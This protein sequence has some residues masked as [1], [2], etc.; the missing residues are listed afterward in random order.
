MEL[1]LKAKKRNFALALILTLGLIAGIPCIVLGAINM[2]DNKGFVALLV[3]GI[4]GT[5]LG[6]YGSPLMWTRLATVNQELT[7]VQAVTQEH[8]YTV[9]DLAQRLSVNGKTASATLNNCIRKGY[10]VGYIREGDRLV[11][12]EP[13]P[14]PHAV[15][16]RLLPLRRNGGTHQRRHRPL[17]LLRQRPLRPEQTLTRPPRTLHGRHP[18]SVFS[19]PAP[20]GLCAASIPFRGAFVVLKDA[21][22]SY[23]TTHLKQERIETNGDGVKPGSPLA[24]LGGANVQLGQMRPSLNIFSGSPPKVFSVGLRSVPVCFGVIRELMQHPLRVCVGLGGE[25]KVHVS[26]GML[27]PLLP[28]GL[29]SPTRN[30]GQSS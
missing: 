19:C 23:L 8:L 6:F 22:S 17:P 24:G 28:F 29:S 4:V 9:A 15:H 13:R 25:N 11:L 27:L 20:P 10:L 16:P 7:V 18:P 5:V 12:R 1:A 30:M 2:G 14:R 26:R 21:L 3:F